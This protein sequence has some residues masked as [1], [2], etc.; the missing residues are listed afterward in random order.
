MS[1]KDF[2]AACVHLPT[3]TWPSISVRTFAKSGLTVLSTHKY[4]QPAFTARLLGMLALEG[5]STL[6]L[7]RKEGLSVALVTGMLEEV[8]E[9]GEIVRDEQGPEGLKWWKNEI[10]AF[11]WVDP[12]G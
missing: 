6:D 9:M 5:V 1:P 7:A 4:A 2:K 11:S 8:E 12:N 10:I 3:Y